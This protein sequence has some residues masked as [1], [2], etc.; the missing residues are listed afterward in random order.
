M[1]R[2]CIKDHEAQDHTPLQLAVIRSWS[3]RYRILVGDDDQNLYEWSGA[4]PQAFF[5]PPLP[6]GQEQVLEQSYRVPKAVHRVATEWVKGINHRREKAYLPRDHEGSV[7]YSALTLMDID[8]GHLPD[9]L[10]NDPD[11]TYM[12]LTSCGYMLDPI[13]AG[14]KSRGISFHNPYRRTNPRWNPL[15]SVM[16]RLDAYMKPGMWSGIALHSW[17]S[18]LRTKGVFRT[19]RKEALVR[20][21]GEEDDIDLDDLKSTFVPSIYDRIMRR[22]ISIFGM[23]RVGATG[24]WEYALRIYQGSEA[25]RQSRV[26][27]GT[28]HSVKGGEADVVYLFPDLSRAGFLDWQNYMT[29]DRVRRLYYVGM[30][31]AR[32]D[33]VLCSASGLSIGW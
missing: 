22:D 9:D 31:R 12:F 5:E 14:L 19:S 28:I 10:L 30:T 29:T 11:K 32:E 4:I 15:A 25:E 27:V 26:I 24:S 16:P 21:S 18:Q 33:L 1:A 17:A 2:D 8:A 6:A 23:R 7:T 13:V 20:W 3:T